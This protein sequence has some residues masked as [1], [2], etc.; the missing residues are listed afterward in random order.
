V[1]HEAV[2]RHIQSGFG[3][4]EW[5]QL[6]PAHPVA[7]LYLAGRRAD[8]DRLLR[9]YTAA[10]E[11]GHAIMGL[12]V[13]L[14]VCE[15]VVAHLH[16]IPQTGAATIGYSQYRVSRRELRNPDPVATVLHD[17]AGIAGH[18]VVYGDQWCLDGA[19][20]T[21]PGEVAPMRDEDT[22]DVG[23]DA[24]QAREKIRPIILSGQRFLGQSTVG[25]A[26]VAAVEQAEA[27]LVARRG[28]LLRLAG[29]LLSY[30]KADR[31]VID[32]I[33]GLPE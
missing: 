30:G 19:S 7:R 6:A 29:H 27:L 5:E 10:H 21:A 3:R 11:A 24:W 15:V 28:A 25:G 20:W 32:Q 18:S 31:A 16:E 9:E 22:S 13:G 33:V 1:V 12:T 8:G 23:G 4:G 14:D 26:M 2:R 17:L